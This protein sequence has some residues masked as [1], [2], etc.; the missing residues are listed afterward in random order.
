M[1]YS[2]WGRK[3]VGHNSSTKRQTA[4]IGKRCESRYLRL[5][6]EF[7]ISRAHSGSST[8]NSKDVYGQRSDSNVTL[9]GKSFMNVASSEKSFLPEYSKVVCC[10]LT[11]NY[12]PLQCLFSQKYLRVCEIIFLMNLS[13]FWLCWVFLGILRL[14]LVT[15]SRGYSLA[16]VHWLLTEVAS[17]VV[18]H[19]F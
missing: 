15:A 2:P 5:L 16:A 1:G 14:S 18:E 19:R 8:T 4:E 10:S 7:S 3:S 12:H 17:L 11:P 9:S 13:H 6:S